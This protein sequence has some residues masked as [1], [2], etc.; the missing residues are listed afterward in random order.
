MHQLQGPSRDLKYPLIGKLTKACLALAHGNADKEQSFSDVANIMKK[1]KGQDPI[2][3]SHIKCSSI[4]E[5]AT[6]AEW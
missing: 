4:C 5:G 2:G 6:V 1:S 3:M